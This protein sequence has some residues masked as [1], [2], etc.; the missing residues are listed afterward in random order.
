MC[1]YVFNCIFCFLYLSDILFMCVFVCFYRLS[2]ATEELALT[3]QNLQTKEA[4]A[5]DL[6]AKIQTSQQSTERKSEW[7]RRITRNKKN[8]SPIDQSINQSLSLCVSLTFS[9]CVLLLS[10]KL[11]LL[12]LHHAVQSLRGSEAR[13]ASQKALLDAKMATA[14][15]PP[16]PPPPPALP[17]EDDARSVGSTVNSYW[18]IFDLS[19]IWSEGSTQLAGRVALSK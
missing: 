15:S 1:F 8:L 13:L 9:S 7:V 12:E 3:Q 5:D 2:S 18:L 11:S 17:Y 6:D 4:L 10:Q 16:P 14:A 19:M